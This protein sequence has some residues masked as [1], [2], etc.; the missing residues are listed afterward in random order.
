MTIKVC[1][2]TNAVI[3]QY[4]LVPSKRKGVGPINTMKPKG[5]NRNETVYLEYPANTCPFGY[6]ITDAHGGKEV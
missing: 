6:A 1:I 5:N 4:I 2:S 3:T